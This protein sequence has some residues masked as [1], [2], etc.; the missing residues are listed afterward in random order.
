MLESFLQAQKVSVRRSLQKSFRKY[1]TYGE[2]SNQLLMHKLLG[3]VVEVEKY[4]KVCMPFRGWI[5]ND[6]VMDRVISS[7]QHYHHLYHHY[8]YDHHYHY[9]HHHQYQHH[10]FYHYHHYHYH[11]HQQQQH[12]IHIHH[13]QSLYYHIVNQQHQQGDRG[14]HRGP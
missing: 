8:Y 11:H 10:H 9:H 3:L 14:I 2:A 7:L 4:K 1:L 12:Q 6:E 13:I 5:C